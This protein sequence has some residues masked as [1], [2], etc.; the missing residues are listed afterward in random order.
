[1]SEGKSYLIDLIAIPIIA[2]LFGL[3][4]NLTCGIFL[5][6]FF[7]MLAE[8]VF[9]YIVLNMTEEIDQGI[10][11]KILASKVFHGIATEDDI[12]KFFNKNN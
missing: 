2:L 10:E 8:L 6:P 4:T 11:R 3:F 5:F 1:M 12:K 9:G 7:F